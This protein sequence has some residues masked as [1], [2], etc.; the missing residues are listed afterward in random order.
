MVHR[1]DFIDSN[2]AFSVKESQVI[3]DTPALDRHLQLIAPRQDHFL[4]EYVI[5]VRMKSVDRRRGLHHDCE[6][7]IDVVSV[8]DRLDH[9]LGQV[10]LLEQIVER[11]VDGVKVVAGR[12]LDLRDAADEDLGLVWQLPAQVIPTD[13][14]LRQLIFVRS[15]ARFGIQVDAGQNSVSSRL[16]AVEDD[17]FIQIASILALHMDLTSWS[18]FFDHE[19]QALTATTH[20]VVYVYFRPHE[21]LLLSV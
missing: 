15:F 11:E 7:I 16:G 2:W 4:V 21:A 17:I 18:I 13:Y 3:D 19:R 1:W 6:A 9:V 8:G 20:V 5:R 14:K 10:D 12:L